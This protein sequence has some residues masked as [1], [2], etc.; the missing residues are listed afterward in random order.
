VEELQSLLDEPLERA[1]ERE[2]RLVDE[3]EAHPN[4]PIVLFGAG[5]LGRRTLSLLHA[6]G[7]DVAAFI[8]N[9][10][11]LWGT[12]VSGVQVL[13]PD[14]ASVRFARD[15]IA[16]VTV[17]RAEGGHD[18][19]VTRQGLRER[20][21][22]RIES[23]IPLYW[24]YAAEALPYLMID[25][26]SKLLAAKEEVLAGAG[27]WADHASLRNYVSL[28]NW[29]LSGDFSALP[30]TE[31]DQ[32]FAAGI[33][34]VGP[35]EVFVD[36]GAFTGDTML[37]VA[38]RVDSWRA[39]HAFEPDPASFV[40]LQGA[41]R[42]LPAHL[43]DRVHLHRAA[44][45]D[46]PYTAHFQATG[47]GSA[48]LSASG[49]FEVACVAVDEVV[50]ESLPTFIKMDIEGAESAALQGC[51]R[52]IREG[53]PALAIAAYHK[54]ADLWELAKQVHDMTPGY[55]TF[56]RPH[57]AEGFDTV[58]YALQSERLPAA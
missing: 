34:R 41:A 47:L 6:K 46:R 21:W 54:Q 24:G 8:D 5:N 25:R 30:I 53:H 52:T 31:P 23:F 2:R 13:S 26:P 7:R 15:G 16:I 40:A 56:L 17:W 3:I 48:S 50:T 19:L 42:T 49:G 10:E 32:Y 18:F 9:S 29:R 22:R 20:G 44:T 57:V 43:S 27:L 1:R 37:D 33:V 51:A 12:E 14:E 36:C 35:D 38:Q 11:V 28:V 39:Y 55:R 45:A 4:M 58:L